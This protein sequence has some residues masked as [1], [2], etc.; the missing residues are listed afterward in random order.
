MAQAPLLLDEQQ[1][2]LIEPDELVKKSA[3]ELDE[4]IYRLGMVRVRSVVLVACFGTVMSLAAAV[5]A[6]AEVL[7][8]APVASVRA[9]M[10]GEQFSLS[11]AVPMSPTSPSTPRTIFLQRLDPSKGTYVNVGAPKTTTN[12]SYR[13]VVRITKKTRFRVSSPGISG[14]ER[15]RSASRLV[16][17]ARQGVAAWIRRGCGSDNRCGGT[18]F[19][20]G[21]VRPVRE[22]RLVVLQILSGG[23]WR[24]IARGRT[25]SAGNFKMSFGISGW[26]QWTARRFRVVASRYALSATSV[27]A[28]MSFMPGP[29]R[30]GRNV[31]RVDVDGGASPA[32]KGRDYRGFATLS[33]NGTDL[34]KRARLD[35]FGVRGSST[36]K[37]AK[38]PYNLRFAK[39]PSVPVFG[40]KAD[41][42]WTLLAM[43]IDQSFVRDKTALDLGQKLLGMTW[44][45]DSD[46]VE[47]FVNSEYKGAYLL[48]EK[49]KIDGDRVNVGRET[50]MIM[51]VDGRNVDDP[52]LGF[53]APHGMVFAF[54]EPDGYKRRTDG[55]YDPDRVTPSKLAAIRAKVSTV[56]SVLYSSKR[57]ANWTKVIDPVSAV[58]FYTHM[59][60]LKDN[61]SDF[62]RS[63]YFTWDRAT[64]CG[65]RLCDTRLHFGPVWDFD[66]G[67]GNQTG[68]SPGSTFVR[69]PIGWNANG[70]GTGYDDR[71][72]YTT[73]WYVQMW[74]IPAFRSLLRTRWEAV[75][76]YYHQAWSQ[77]VARNKALIGV[78]AYNDRKRWAAYPKW[79]K[80]KG[81][82]YEAEVQYVA[83]W[84]KRRYVWMN[85]QLD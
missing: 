1:A 67:A 55:T 40:M 20:E 30:I 82:T 12:G 69:S 50:G 27:S 11:G 63:K 60:F 48:A 62:W 8:A 7:V 28:G 35:K 75:K 64:T 4:E 77:E 44:S 25:N 79:Y 38:K 18:G 56:E 5:P 71:P 9:P 72:P 24:V 6:Q 14:A 80:S 15:A 29:T 36:A 65:N 53:R 74:K 26:S 84:M 85:G 81:P 54:K 76:S 21:Y 37:F 58:D 16:P 33:R 19:A 45:A 61:D 78:G 31:L 73:H 13:F 66:R 52:R 46:Y 57:Y 22:R 83:S 47:M 42:S 3:A 41:T 10:S 23:S 43:F 2:G 17:V 34:I 70:K 68:T 51:E 49:V 59:E 32:A 39:T